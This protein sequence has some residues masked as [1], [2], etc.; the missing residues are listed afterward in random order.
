MRTLPRSLAAG[1]MTLF[2]LCA[3]LVAPENA[4]AVD[5][6]ARDANTPPATAT[7]GEATAS[8][9]IEY[10]ALGDSYASG[11]GLLPETGSPQPTCW[12]SY[13]NYPHQ[14]ASQFGFTLE[15]RSCTGAATP[16]IAQDPQPLPGGA[17]APLQ[18]EAL[19]DN[20]D[21]VTI[22]IGGN[23]AGFF[24]IASACLALDEK[25]P[26]AGEDGAFQSPNCREVYERPEGN[27]LKDRID[28]NVRDGLRRN[29]QAVAEAAPNADIYVV[30]YPAVV[31]VGGKIPAH[32]CFRPVIGLDG[33]AP[34]SV[35]FTDE[36]I[37]FIAEIVRELNRTVEEEASAAGFT[38]VN[39]EEAS[40]EHS[41][42]A[43]RHESYIAGITITTLDPPTAQQGALHPNL[44]GHNYLANTA[45]DAIQ[46]KHPELERTPHEPMNVM[47]PLPAKSAQP[48]GRAA[49][50]GSLGGIVLVGGTLLL[51][52][53][54]RRMRV[55]Q[56]VR[57]TST[58]SSRDTSE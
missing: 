24:N 20:T 27:I 22:T 12:Q 30:G 35:P 19:S 43:P 18:I 47:P 16:N 25:G 49:I 9:P 34:D 8:D 21:F 58:P 38:F 52:E 32:G 45:A 3:A 10:V 46:T 5:T 14:L 39:T 48:D 33:Y 7:S 53:R 28:Y 23:D 26:V 54:R 41:V 44:P 6:L 51:L 2:A 56:R 36:D 15:D 42:C 13:N 57:A 29:F 31:P 55:V 40:S 1:V 17:T 4:L 37:T 11:Y 50:F